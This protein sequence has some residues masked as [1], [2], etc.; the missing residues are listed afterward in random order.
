[1]NKPVTRL[2]WKV[3]STIP[4][5]E[6]KGSGIASSGHALETSEDKRR[7]WTINVNKLNNLDKTDKL[8]ERQIT[9]TES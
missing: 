9:K 4:G 2:I 5:M 3:G 6:K 7:L 1:M 8:F